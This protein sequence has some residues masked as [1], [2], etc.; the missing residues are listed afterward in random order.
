M[1]EQC[2]CGYDLTQKPPDEAPAP[3]KKKKKRRRKRAAEEADFVSVIHPQHV[4][5]V[6]TLMLLNIVS[7]GIYAAY[8]YLMRQP[9]V[10]SLHSQSKVGRGMPTFVIAGSAI[11]IAGVAFAILLFEADPVV[12]PSL[13]IVARLAGF[14]AG[15]VNL[16]LAF[17]VRAALLD[18][19]RRYEPG[20]SVS[21]VAT[22]FFN[23]LYLQYKINRMTV[24]AK[25]DDIVQE[26]A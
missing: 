17:K 2:A 14:A 9:L 12:G 26:F 23:V 11:N 20:Y 6:L 21:A 19:T 22:F 18:H 16:I 8:W 7:C 10:D 24:R 5:G 1:D 15:I 4:Q 25:I 3:K 13:E